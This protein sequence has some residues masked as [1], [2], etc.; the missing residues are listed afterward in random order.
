M[1]QFGWADC[2]AAVQQQVERLSNG[3]HT[4]LN[5][6]LAG[7]YLHGS[8]AMACFN[9]ERSD[10]DLLVVTHTALSVETKRELI[11]LLLHE[12][13]H[14]IPVEISFLTTEQLRS[15]SY[16]TP[17][18]LHYGEDW[19]DTYKADLENGNWQ[20]W[21]DRIGR[22]P[23][24]AAHFT[25]LRHRGICLYGPSIA[26]LFPDVPHNDYLDS[27]RGD[28]KEALTELD[29]Y[30]VYA[31]LNL[32]RV[33][34]YVQ[35]RKIASKDEAGAWAVEQP[36]LGDHPAIRQAIAYYRGDDEHPPVV[37]DTLRA[38]ATDMANRIERSVAEQT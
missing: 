9:P 13:T 35:E 5:D 7:L 3:F 31:I 29:D 1:A 30:P 36:T 23:D 28:A 27:I 16:P 17:F 34:W 26:S 18:D 32:C 38:W 15:W 11:D 10:L 22:D 20:T 12:S 25:I 2:P 4:L 6:N 19:R 33:L 21:N 24:L 37:D 8:L 14:P